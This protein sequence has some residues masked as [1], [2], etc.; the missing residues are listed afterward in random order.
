[1]PKTEFRV[2]LAMTTRLYATRILISL[3]SAPTYS[4]R[5]RLGKNRPVR[6]MYL[7]YSSPNRSIKFSS[8]VRVRNTIRPK[9]IPP[10]RA[11]N[12]FAVTR[13][14]AVTAKRKAT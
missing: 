10:V 3:W 1:M 2:N 12:Q 6:S 13:E 7:R 14:L 8:S 9:A 5:T 4:P 11:R